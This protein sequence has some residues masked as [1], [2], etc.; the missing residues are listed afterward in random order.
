MRLHE[1]MDSR[2]EFRNLLNIEIKLFVKI[3]IIIHS[4]TIFPKRHTVDKM[5]FSITVF[6]SKCDQICSF[7]RIWSHL[8]E[9]SLMEKFIFCAVSHDRYLTGSYI[10]QSIKSVRIWSFSVLIFPHAD[11]IRRDIRNA[12]LN[13]SSNHKVI[14]WYHIYGYF[15]LDDSSSM[16]VSKWIFQSGFTHII[17]KILFVWGNGKN[18]I[19]QT[20]ILLISL[21][22]SILWQ[23]WSNLQ[24]LFFKYFV[25]L[26]LS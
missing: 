15:F 17:Y 12:L 4:S 20:L 9:K 8:L 18:T 25:W 22:F 2:H 7:L 11:W 10:L 23:S 24:T 26:Y 3:M 21:I 5:K 19:S 6:F 1:L 14:Q 13:K 16:A